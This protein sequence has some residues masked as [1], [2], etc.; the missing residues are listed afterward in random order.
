MNVLSLLGVVTLILVN[1]FLS[2]ASFDE[3]YVG[4]GGMD[5]IN[6]THLM[7]IT[8]LYQCDNYVLDS[9]DE[10]NPKM[11]VISV[12][13]DKTAYLNSTGN[14]IR[15]MFDYNNTFTIMADSSALYLSGTSWTTLE[16]GLS[17]SPW[18][19][20]YWG[21][22]YSSRAY[23]CNGV[24]QNQKYLAT[25][26]LLPMQNEDS[27]TA[28]PG[29]IT[30]YNNLYYATADATAYASI[31]AGRY[32]IPSSSN[33]DTDWQEVVSKTAPNKLNLAKICS[34][35]TQTSATCVRSNY[36]PI[37]RHQIAFEGHEV[38]GYTN[39][40][41]VASNSLNTPSSDYYIL[42]GATGIAQS[43]EAIA[44]SLQKVKLNIWKSGNID[45]NI[46]ISIKS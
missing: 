25:G 43:F 10:E 34:L 22:P 39:S 26:G 44:T 19:G 38:L 31:E 7:P 2:P 11:S 28:I 5:R 8:S 9:K 45:G 41:V 27:Q 1:V 33:A 42:Y 13:P 32:I 30:F 37:S 24:N 35:Q 18:E 40:G 20:V 17:D 3:T 6:Q 36:C 29:N 15:G 4:F 23:L 21:D 16:A 14:P 12:R 46:I